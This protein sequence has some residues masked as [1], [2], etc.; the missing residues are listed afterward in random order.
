[1]GANPQA[2]KDDGLG[3]QNRYRTGT[4]SA[5]YGARDLPGLSDFEARGEGRGIE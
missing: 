3:G 4:S 1:M 5:Q 2:G